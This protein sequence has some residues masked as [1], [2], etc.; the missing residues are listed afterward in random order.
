MLEEIC[1][2][3]IE[4]KYWASIFQN[5]TEKDRID[6]WDYQM[7]YSMW[8]QGGL[9]ILPSVNM[10]TN[11]GFRPDATHTVVDDGNPLANML[12]HDIHRIDYLLS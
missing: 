3:E 10:T 1:K 5:M 7:N 11:L 12:R 2:D 8:S 4:A 6:T 9:A